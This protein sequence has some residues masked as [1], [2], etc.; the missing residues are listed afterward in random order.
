MGAFGKLDAEIDHLINSLISQPIAGNTT[1]G[2]TQYTFWMAIAIVVLLAVVF[3]AIKRQQL[4]PQGR[5]VNAFEYVFEFVRN[6]VVDGVIGPEGRKHLPFIM[7][8]FFFI[9]INNLIGLIPGAKPGTGTIGVTLALALCSFI[10]F[11]YFGIKK[12]GL[13]GYLKTF[14]P[15]GVAFPINIMVWIIELFSTAIR[16]VTL[17][18]RL[19]ANLFAGHVVL[20][21][22]AILTSLFIAEAIQEMTLAAT[23]GALSSILWMALLIILYLVEVVVASIQAYVFTVLSAVY[24]Q[25]AI[26]D[27][28]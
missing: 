22:F 19:F 2:V 6:E 27:E 23:A 10:Y 14:S 17:A 20:G 16:L 21:V 12:H 9:F 7:S 11:L 3:G 26:S 4:I 15:H 25:I 8:V 18:V 24:I 13:I 1:F 28:H 5:F